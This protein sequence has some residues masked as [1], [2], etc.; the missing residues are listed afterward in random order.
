MDSVVRPAVVRPVGLVVVNLRVRFRDNLFPGLHSFEF[1]TRFWLM[2]WNVV[3]LLGIE[4]GID[5]MDQC[6][7]ALIVLLGRRRFTDRRIHLVRL[8]LFHIP[9]LNL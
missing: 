4:N 9:K 1:G 5:A 6:W 7:S 8:R 3:D 2:R